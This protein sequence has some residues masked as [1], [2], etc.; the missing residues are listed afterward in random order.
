MKLPQL[1]RQRDSRREQPP[2]PP[3]IQ[4]RFEERS[5]AD[6]PD[7]DDSSN[8]RLP[9]AVRDSH[10]RHLHEL[11]RSCGTEPGFRQEDSY[12]YWRIT[13]RGPAGAPSRMAPRGIGMFRSI[14]FC[15]LQGSECHSG[16]EN[17]CP[18]LPIIRIVNEP[19]T[20]GPWPPR[21]P[22]GGGAGAGPRSWA[23][24]KRWPVLLSNVT[25]RAPFIV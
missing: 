10:L 16:L 11:R 9:H 18:Y 19:N 12:R 2:Y 14:L 21:P 4:C 3:A 6:S 17:G 5:G 20:G 24:V 7:L 22:P 8:D 1:E 15:R 25:V 13:P 23:I